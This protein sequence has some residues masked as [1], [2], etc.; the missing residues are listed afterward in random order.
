MLLAGFILLAFFNPGTIPRA[1]FE[2][3][4]AALI[5]YAAIPAFKGMNVPIL[6]T[7]ADA[8]FSIYITHQFTFRLSRPLL[9]GMGTEHPGN[10]TIALALF[11]QMAVSALL[12]VL[13]H[14]WFEKPVTRWLNQTLMKPKD[15][16]HESKIPPQGA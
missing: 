8:S 4:C 13:V 9:N 1:Y 7:L 3:L 15:R 16:H 14:R 12:G 10:S 2:G 11:V 5:V 6:H